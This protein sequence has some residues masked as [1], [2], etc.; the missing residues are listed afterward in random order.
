MSLG[1]SSIW[2]TQIMTYREVAMKKWYLT[3]FIITLNIFTGCETA[4]DLPEAIKSSYPNQVMVEIRNSLDFPVTE[5]PVLIDLDS[6]KGVDPEFNQEAWVAFAGGEELAG[7]LVDRDHNDLADHLL[8]LATMAAHESKTIYLRYADQ[9]KIARSYAKRTQ[10][11][12]SHKFGGAFVQNDEGR[13]VYKDG[14]FKNV[15]RLRVPPEHTDHTFYIRYEGPGWESDKVG[16]RFYLDWRNATDIFGKKVTRPVLQNVG[17]D[18]F[19]S[20]HEMADWGMDILKV[21][22]ALG[23]G[24]VGYWDGEKAIRISDTD[25]VI[26]S[27]TADGAI[28]SEVFTKYYGWQTGRGKTDLSSALSILAGDRKTRHE[29]IIDPE[30]DGLCTGIVKHE[31]VKVLRKMDQTS[32]WGFLA[33]YGSQSL[34]GDSLGMA[35]IFRNNDVAEI[36]ED[37]LN[38]VI[39]LKTENGNV[40]FY[41]LAAWEQE[42]G[43]IVS[44]KQFE[45]YLEQEIMRLN[46]PVQV[47]F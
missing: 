46:N 20:Y 33:T 45:Q 37:D 16:Y 15:S 11:E 4:A 17:Q 3:L 28:F 21:G 44:Q 30:I 34:A 23:I 35:L 1:T 9:G 26:C 40:N 14:A 36:T 39:M 31:G 27:I 19:D 41:F 10:A 29:V 24:A 22:D 47:S 13:M 32:G 7:Q 42:P 12:L 43:G 38:H 5:I 2:L 25:S 18:G 8:L 6:L